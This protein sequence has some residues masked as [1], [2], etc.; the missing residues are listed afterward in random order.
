MN[1]R[2]IPVDREA[3]RCR[4]HGRRHARARLNA[5]RWKIAIM[6]ERHNAASNGEEELR[7][8]DSTRTRAADARALDKSERRRGARTFIA[9]LRNRQL[10]RRH[11]GRR[12][13]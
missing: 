9:R 13:R 3:S 2:I 5:G 11:V 7:K 1:L 8:S 10:G 4:N 12:A 6:S